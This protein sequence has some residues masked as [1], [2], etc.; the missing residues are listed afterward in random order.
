[1][2]TRLSEQAEA[3]LIKWA[4]TELLG[5][6]E[7]EACTCK[8][9]VRGLSPDG[10]TRGHV[11]EVTRSL[12]AARLVENALR[13]GTNDETWPRY[14]SALRRL[15]VVPDMQ[16]Q[17][18][19]AMEQGITATPLQRI[20]AAHFAVTGQEFSSAASGERE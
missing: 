1:M 15:V 6:T 3:E 12:D 19:T 5:W 16:F 18:Q 8:A 11:P 7:V 10:K 9:K 2:E 20:L 13:L 4:V 17:W 14:L